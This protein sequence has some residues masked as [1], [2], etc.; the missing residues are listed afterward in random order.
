MTQQLLADGKQFAEAAIARPVWQ[1]DGSAD[2]YCRCRTLPFVLAHMSEWHQEVDSHFT[3]IFKQWNDWER[4]AIGEAA[5]EVS[6]KKEW[7]PPNAYHTFWALE[8]IDNYREQARLDSQYKSLAKALDLEARRLRMHQWAYQRLTYEAALHSA[9]SSALDSDQLAWSLAVFLRDPEHY[10]SK[11]PAQD[12]IRQ[13]F[14]CL[15]GTQAETGTWHHYNPLFHYLYSGNAYCYIFETFAWLLKQAL[16]PGADFTR[17]LLK[18]YFGN[19]IHLWKYATVTQTTIDEGHQL[20][21]SSGHRVNE[22]LPES[23]A[24]ASVFAYAQA[25]RRLVGLW[26]RDEALRSVNCRKSSLAPEDARRDLSDLSKSWHRSDVDVTELLWSMFVHPIPETVEQDRLEPDEQP[27]DEPAPRSAILFGPPGT[28]K[29]SLV[30]AIA[31]SIGWHYVEL[32]PSH[33]VAEGLPEVQH[34]AD[35]IFRALMELDHAVVL[36]D[37]VEELVRERDIEPD[38]FGRFLTTSMLPR[39]AELWKARKIMYFVATNHIEYFDRAVTRSQRFDA[40]L[41]IGPLSF[42]AKTKRLEQILLK[43]YQ[44][45]AHFDGSVTQEAIDAAL[46][47]ELID[48]I[49]QVQK[50]EEQDWLKAR[51]LADNFTLAKF[52]LLRWDELAE[53]ASRLAPR[54]NDTALITLAALEGALRLVRDSKSRTLGEY[55][56]FATD[57][58]YERYDV[59]KI[60]CWQVEIEGFDSKNSPPAPVEAC[61]KHYVVRV[62]IGSSPNLVI[63]GYT[64]QC[65][66]EAKLRLKRVA[67]S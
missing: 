22:T 27:I 48:K 3:T 45:E 9:K 31:A 67:P 28:G 63:A 39:L 26:T 10:R 41:Y 36:F 8:A 49:D 29:T 14:K 16:R 58:K 56:R 15:F 66:P 1:S 43:T 59:S 4:P 20:A 12:L 60:A 65:L 46:P 7:Y 18:Q 61:G 34:T 23:W 44:I 47:T 19:L 53:L 21:W 42:E 2:I 54:L 35:R 50:K 25:L 24:T 64:V 11:V 51:S 17:T 37:E 33:F 13:A 32:H 40:I 30:R 52:A 57:F 62:Q 55:Y 6:D 38:Q 5:P